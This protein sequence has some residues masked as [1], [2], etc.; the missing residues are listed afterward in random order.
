[1]PHSIHISGMPSRR[2]AMKY[3]IM[4]VP[5][6]FRAASAGKRRKLPSPTAFPAIASTRPSCDAQPSLSTTSLS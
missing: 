3:G 1:M 6:P 5:P 2:K 4:K